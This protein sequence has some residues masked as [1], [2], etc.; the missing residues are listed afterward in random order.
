MKRLIAA[1]VAGFCLWSTASAQAE[2]TLGAERIATKF[3]RGVANFTTGWLE[4]PKQISIVSREEG[5]VKGAMR[6]SIEGLGMFLARTLAGAYEILT[7]PVPLPP[8]YQPMLQPEY[9]WEPEPA[10]VEASWMS[11]ASAAFP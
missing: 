7:F 2:D 9:V 4:I 6:G 11:P 8:G 3:V 10:E 1:V 5:W